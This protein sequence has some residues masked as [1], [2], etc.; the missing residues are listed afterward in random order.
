MIAMNGSWAL[1]PTL[2]KRT[3]LKGNDERR[4]GREIWEV[5]EA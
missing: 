5:N 2:R 3:E 1:P 4:V